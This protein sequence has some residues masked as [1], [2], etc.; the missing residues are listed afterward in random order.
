MWERI[1]TKALIPK[2]AYSI[3]RLM[4]RVPGVRSLA[5]S[6]LFACQKADSSA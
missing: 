1:F 4:S 6:V 3:D 2:A 5:S